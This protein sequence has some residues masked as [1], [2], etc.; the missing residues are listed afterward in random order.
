VQ[1]GDTLFGISKRF[2]LT[3]EQIKALNTLAGNQLQVG[4][5][6][7]LAGLQQDGV[8]V[9]ASTVG[10]PAS[11][12][13]ASSA[14]AKALPTI[15]IVKAGDTL[16]GIAQKFGVALGDLMRWNKLTPRSVIQPGFKVK[17]DV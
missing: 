10:V 5:N 14:A 8:S 15:Y 9:A 11:L 12:V 13:T 4:Q 7:I 17:L 3:I 1:K 16:F 2:N 6:L